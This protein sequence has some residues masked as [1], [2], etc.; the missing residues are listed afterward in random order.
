MLTCGQIREK[1]ESMR[2]AHNMEDSTSKEDAQAVNIKEK[3]KHGKAS[4]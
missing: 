3:M 1:S 4:V 2:G